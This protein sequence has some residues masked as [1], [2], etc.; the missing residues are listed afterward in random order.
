MR[1][2]LPDFKAR[3]LRDQTLL[4]EAE[5]DRLLDAGRAWNLAPT[6]RAGGALVFPHATLTVCGHQIAAAV[7]ACLECG[8]RRVLALGVLHALTPELE[9]TRVRVANGGDP[10]S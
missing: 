3:T 9:E 8:A 6:L 2:N 4:S 10:A 5:I 1:R 7:Q